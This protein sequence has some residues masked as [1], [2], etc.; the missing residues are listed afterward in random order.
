MFE[1]QEKKKCIRQS[2]NILW[3]TWIW[4]HQ[5]KK[6]GLY[7]FY[8]RLDSSTLEFWII[9]LVVGNIVSLIGTFHL[10]FDDGSCLVASAIKVV[11]VL[12]LG[13]IN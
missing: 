9:C 4:T 12:C 3:N 11:A 2:R 6:V 1:L 5:W 7:F 13:S 10:L 8:Q